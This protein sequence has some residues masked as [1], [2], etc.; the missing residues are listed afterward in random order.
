MQ[1]PV[2]GWALAIW[3]LSVLVEDG[4]EEREVVEGAVLDGV[5]QLRDAR[6]VE[7]FLLDVAE[8]F[9]Q[10]LPAFAEEPRLVATAPGQTGE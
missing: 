10:L 3:H 7:F 2:L 9:E 5:V 8:I 4:E 6:W 1:A